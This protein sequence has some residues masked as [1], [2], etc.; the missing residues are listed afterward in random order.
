M[1]YNFGPPGQG[2]ARHAVIILQLL[3]GKVVGKKVIHV[4]VG[5]TSCHQLLRTSKAISAIEVEFRTFFVE[6]ANMME[7]SFGP[8][9]IEMTTAFSITKGLTLLDTTNLE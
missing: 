7:R 9:R 5:C 1:Y 6:S 4:D 2:Q 8:P 3:H